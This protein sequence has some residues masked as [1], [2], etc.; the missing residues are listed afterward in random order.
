MLVNACPATADPVGCATKHSGL[1]T[2][3]LFVTLTSFYTVYLDEMRTR[4][5][6]NGNLTIV[7]V[8]L[9]AQLLSRFGFCFR[10]IPG[11]PLRPY[12][13]PLLPGPTGFTVM[14]ATS[15]VARS[16]RCR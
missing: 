9:H 14:L 7:K 5:V 11:S 2:R 15:W 13:P 12:A 10:K 16:H 4:G 6:S 3:G 8:R 1:L